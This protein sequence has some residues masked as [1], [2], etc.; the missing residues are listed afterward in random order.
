M[1]CD[2]TMS[3]KL[4]IYGS[5]TWALRQKEEEKLVRT[6][7]RMLGWNMGVSPLKK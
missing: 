2:K 1:V 4:K 7:I 6:E 5:E 3:V